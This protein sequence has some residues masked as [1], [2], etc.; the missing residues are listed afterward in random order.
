MPLQEG[1]HRFQT[2]INSLD[3]FIAPDHPI[4][5]IDALVDKLDLQQLCISLP[6]ATE[7]RPAFHPKLFLKLYL[8]GYT[9][10]IRSSRK[11]E[12][13]CKRNMEVRWL[14]EELQPCYK[15]IADFRKEHPLQLKKVFRMFTAFLQEQDLI[16]GKI[17]VADGS[18]FRAVNSRKNNYNLDKIERHK[19]YISKKTEEYLQQLDANDKAEKH[20][21]ELEIKRTAILE[22]LKSLKNRELKYDH[23]ESQIRQS[24]ETQVSTTDGESR[25]LLINHNQI[26][27]SYNVQTVSDEKHSLVAHFEV[28]SENDT[29]ALFKT[30]NDAK[31]ELEKETITVIADKG[32]STGEQMTKCEQAGIITLVAPKDVTS[33][34]H[35]EEKYLVSNFIYNDESDTYTCPAG[36]TLTTNGNWYTRSHDDRTRKNS[37]TYKVKHYK[38]TACRHCPLMQACTQNKRGRLLLRS[39][40]QPTVDR[41]NAR[42]K[43]QFTLYKRRQELIEHIFGTVKRAWGFTYTLLKGKKKITG[44][45]SLIYLAYNFTRAKNILGFDKMLEAINNWTPKYPKGFGFLL[46]RLVYITYKPVRFFS[47]YRLLYFKAALN[48]G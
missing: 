26:E 46:F 20:S 28:T 11:L 2:S 15:T 43:A 7:G 17:V 4:R 8:Y 41:N 3:D 31:Q 18:K 24:D 30:T 23:L 34:K 36:E 22:K 35:L 44:E 1:T 12:T 39:E 45:F 42:V 29:K 5:L 25:A 37:T 27:V 14:L 48:P 38:T 13:E 33:V 16:A 47:F 40:H 10:R 6:A 21:D 9:N 19:E 32:Y